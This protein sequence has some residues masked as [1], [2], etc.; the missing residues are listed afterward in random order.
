[1]NWRSKR[2][3]LALILGVCV[4]LA[5]AGAAAAWLNRNHTTC[6]DGKPPLRQ[7]P[8]ILG[9]TVYQCQNGQLVTTP[10]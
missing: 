8:G 5:G 4:L 9:Q 6:R 2:Q 3:V 7:R 10:G 1:M